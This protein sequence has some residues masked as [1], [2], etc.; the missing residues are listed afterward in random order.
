MNHSKISLRLSL[1]I[2]FLSALLL[3]VG[4]IGLYGVTKGD[5]ALNT[6]YSQRT[7]PITLL[8]EIQYLQLRSQLALS[9]AQLE[10]TD[11][12]TAIASK[13]VEA[14]TAQANKLWDKYV[15]VPMSAEEAP[16]AKAYWDNQT[17]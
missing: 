16:L 10:A 6:V 12:Q 5:Q 15:Q 4:G 9:L 3:I 7:V 11:K 13:I 8:S 2:G 17:Q 1:L 14:N